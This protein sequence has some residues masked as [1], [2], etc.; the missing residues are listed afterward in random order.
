VLMPD[1]WLNRAIDILRIGYQRLTSLCTLQLTG[2]TLNNTDGDGLFGGV[3]RQF[4]VFAKKIA[5]GA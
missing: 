2:L 5:C 3:Q 1:Q 4:A